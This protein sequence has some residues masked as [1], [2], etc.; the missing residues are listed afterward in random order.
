MV[1]QF[2]V[3]LVC[4]V[5]EVTGSFPKAET[6]GL[7]SQVQRAAVSVPSNIAEGHAVP[8]ENFFIS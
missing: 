1:W 6:Y 3:N 2:G 4:Q 7:T 8:A 5:Y